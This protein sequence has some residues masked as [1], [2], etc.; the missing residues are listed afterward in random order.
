MQ[1]PKLFMVL[2]G[3][4]P[5][6]RNVEQHDIFFGIANSMQDLVP[7]MIAFWPEAKNKI[8]VDAYRIINKV[9][10]FKVEV[11]AKDQEINDQ[12]QHL[13]FLNLGGYRKDEFEELH[14]KMLVVATE[15]AIAIKEAKETAF[16]KDSEFKGASSHIDDK[17]GVDVDDIFEIKDILSAET[18]GKYALQFIPSRELPEDEI[19]LGYLPFSKFV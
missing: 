3:A 4:T 11:V 16:Y 17:F 14:Y 8:H 9:G 5:E 1:T 6:G 18:K 12:L 7:E 13:F 19:V 2:L 10:N 15:K